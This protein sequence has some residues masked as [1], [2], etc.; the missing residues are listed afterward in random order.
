MA[1]ICMTTISVRIGTGSDHPLRNV[2]A[3]AGEPFVERA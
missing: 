3:V 1:A 2:G